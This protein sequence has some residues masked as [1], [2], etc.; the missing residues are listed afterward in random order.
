M[1]TIAIFLILLA[2]QHLASAQKPTTP[3]KKVKPTDSLRYERSLHMVGKY[4]GDSVVLRWSPS[5]PLLWRA[6]NDAGYVIERMEITPK[7][8][9][10]PVRE[11]LNASPIK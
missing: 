7:M 11:K 2:A 8:T 1:R 9:T 3:Q 10:R 4:S 6:Y 5:D